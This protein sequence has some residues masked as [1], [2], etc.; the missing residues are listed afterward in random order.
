MVRVEVLPCVQ[1]DL[2]V[3]ALLFPVRVYAD[4][5]ED[6]ET[7]LSD[8]LLVVRQH[9]LLNINLRDNVVQCGNS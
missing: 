4:V 3:D 2:G 5:A 1:D 7:E 6:A 8:L 9:Y